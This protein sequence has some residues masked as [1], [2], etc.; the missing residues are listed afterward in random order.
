MPREASSSMYVVSAGIGARP[1]GVELRGSWPG[2]HALARHRAAGLLQQRQPHAGALGRVD[3]DAHDLRPVLEEHAAKV[4]IEQIDF[5]RGLAPLG[6][7]DLIEPRA[8]VRRAIGADGHLVRAALGHRDAALGELRPVRRTADHLGAVPPVEARPRVQTHAHPAARV[9]RAEMVR[10]E[11]PAHRVEA[12]LERHRLLELGHTGLGLGT[13]QAQCGTPAAASAIARPGAADARVPAGEVAGRRLEVGVLDEVRPRRLGAGQ[14]GQA[15]DGDHA[16]LGATYGERQGGSE[17]EQPS[18]HAAAAERGRGHRDGSGTGARTR[19]SSPAGAASS[20]ARTSAAKRPS[21]IV[22][23]TASHS[24]FSYWALMK[25]PATRKPM[26]PLRRPSAQPAR[27]RPSGEAPSRV[28]R[29]RMWKA[30]KISMTNTTKTGMPNSAATS[31]NELWAI[32]PSR[33]V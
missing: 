10:L 18:E 31:R 22:T 23:N 7:A 6:E 2:H 11:P 26:R 1:R 14:C 28:A 12:R 13:G 27:S 20:A 21:T 19:P 4:G 5:E 33:P 29:F 24:I 3:G 32:L 16:V 17:Q 8:A 30:A 9:L 15:A 25:K